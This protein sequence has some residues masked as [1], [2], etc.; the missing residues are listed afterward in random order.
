MTFIP[1]ITNKLKSVFAQHDL[2][3]VF[4]SAN[5]LRHLLRPTK[6]TTD[7]DSKPGI[8]EVSCPDCEDKYVGQTSRTITARFKEHMRNVKYNRPHLS[9]VAKHILENGHWNISADSSRLVH[10]VNNKLR[11][12][13]YESYYIH[14]QQHLMNTDKGNIESDLFSLV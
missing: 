8:Y 9:A 10:V 11:L 4:T 7:R 3:I 1:T 13:A 5:K 14:R 2:E 12:D 6:D